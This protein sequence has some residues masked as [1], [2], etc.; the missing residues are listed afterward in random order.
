MVER[1]R[2]NLAGKES[3]DPCEPPR[4]STDV[5][6]RISGSGPG[7]SSFG[8]RR[9]LPSGS[10]PKSSGSGSIGS[11]VFGLRFNLRSPNCVTGDVPPSAKRWYEIRYAGC[12]CAWKQTNSR[13][14]R[15][16][17]TVWVPAWHVYSYQG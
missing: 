3:L 6:A 5:C 17:W 2:R 16:T 9:H 1:S 15:D 14:L 11:I 7:S 4:P 13:Y 8:L 10:R 12:T